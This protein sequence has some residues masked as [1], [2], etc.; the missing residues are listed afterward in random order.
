MRIQQMLQICSIGVLLTAWGTNAQYKN[1]GSVNYQHLLLSYDARTA[2][3]GGSG[4]ALPG[5]I[6]LNTVNPAASASTETMQWFVGYQNLGMGIWGSVMSFSRPYE[7]GIMTFTLQGLSSGAIDVIEVK[8]SS[9]LVTGRTAHDE[10]LTPSVS[11]ARPFLS[12]KMLVG[13][14]VKGMYQRIDAST[15]VY[16]S[17][18]IGFDFGFQYRPVNNRL[19]AAA[20]VRN[21]GYEF[22]SFIS[23]DRYPTPMVFEAGISYIPR[24]LPSLRVIADINKSRGSDLMYEPGF[25]IEA[26]PGVLALRVGYPFSQ[27]DLDEKIRSFSGEKDPLYVKSNLATIACGAGIKTDIRNKDVSI[28]IALQ[29]KDD[30]YPPTVQISSSVAF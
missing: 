22:Q 28:D 8:N 16:S 2:A 7:F 20:V 3:L 25:E 17:K 18:A 21:I 23:N 14:S 30:F 26:Y 12:G 15:D 13:A 5:A 11:L 9:P 4:C 10:Y 27:A 19:I 29:F 24:Y 6:E 1:A